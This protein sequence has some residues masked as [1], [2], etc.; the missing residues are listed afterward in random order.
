MIVKK[1]TKNYPN[2]ESNHCSLPTSTL[3]MFS[4][5]QWRSVPPVPIGLSCVSRLERSQCGPLCGPKHRSEPALEE[6]PHTLCPIRPPHWL[7]ALQKHTSLRSLPVNVEGFLWSHDLLW[8]SRLT[9]CKIFILTKKWILHAIYGRLTHEFFTLV[10]QVLCPWQL[11][12]GR[13]HFL[14]LLEMPQFSKS[15]TEAD[16]RV[17][18]F[19]LPLWASVFSGILWARHP[20]E[21]DSSALASPG[22]KFQSWP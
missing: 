16:V 11:N 7:Y 1:K 3:Q 6:W 17:K 9:D 2:W 4:H 14:L 15:T 10:C 18:S 12:E 22:R 8:L 5:N 20:Q 21:K 13:E 19:S